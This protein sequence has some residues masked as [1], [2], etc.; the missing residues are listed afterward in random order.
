MLPLVKVCEHRPS[1]SPLQLFLSSHTSQTL[2]T[3]NRVQHSDCGWRC[4]Y[5]LTASGAKAFNPIDDMLARLAPFF[6]LDA[7]M[8]AVLALY[9]FA[10]AVRGAV[11][12]GVRMCGIKLFTVKKRAT[13]PHAL[14]FAAFLLMFVVLVVTLQTM[15]L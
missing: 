7:A 4:G 8:F 13:Q 6:P 12:L 15:T 14:V 11:A 1:H 10:A 5:A 9:I 2:A 3:V